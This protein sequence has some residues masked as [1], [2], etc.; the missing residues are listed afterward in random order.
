MRTGALVYHD[1]PYQ[2]GSVGHII[3]SKAGIFTVA[4]EAVAMP[5]KGSNDGGVNDTKVVVKDDTLVFPHC[6]ISEPIEIGKAQCQA[7]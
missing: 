1:I 5:L 7:V 3:V 2:N 6:T 4:T